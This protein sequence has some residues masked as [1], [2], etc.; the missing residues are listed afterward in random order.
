LGT[1][2]IPTTGLVG[3]TY[4]KLVPDFLAPTFAGQEIV[5]T[6]ATAATT[7]GA[8]LLSFLADE[9]PEVPLNEV[10]LIAST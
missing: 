7:A 5:Y 4:Y 1:I 8:A 3:Q 2:N 9:S 10:Q 6:V